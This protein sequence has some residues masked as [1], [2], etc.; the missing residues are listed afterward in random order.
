[1]IPKVIH[2][3][4]I[5]DID[6]SKD[7]KLQDA[8]QSWKTFNPDYEIREWYEQ[9]CI[10]YLQE[11][12]GDSFVKTFNN[13]IPYCYK[14]DFFRVC[15]I[16][17]E[18][19]WYSDWKQMCYSKIE[20]RLQDKDLVCF[21]QNGTYIPMPLFACKPKH[22]ILK[23][24]INTIIDNVNKRYYGD[25]T[26]CPTSNVLYINMKKYE[27]K[28]TYFGVFRGNDFFI[29]NKLFAQHKYDYINARRQRENWNNDYTIMW[30][31]RNVYS[32]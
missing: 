28:N 2:F 31:E 1:M 19:G 12:Y 15:L 18:G 5:G 21:K 14:C 26:H 17:K 24:C 27:C 22:F 7:K 9:D 25:N 8:H 30:K 20:Q 29:E 23:H 11:N 4:Y 10:N 16:Y 32:T 6:F 3:V 13:L